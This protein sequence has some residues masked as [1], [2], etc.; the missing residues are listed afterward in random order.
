M[1]SLP[2]LM[3]EQPILYGPGDVFLGNPTFQVL[4]EETW[5]LRAADSTE[6]I[7]SCWG[8]DLMMWALL[9]VERLKVESTAETAHPTVC[10]SST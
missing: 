2:A 1:P 3:G 8:W 4:Q 7:L 10:A 6:W 9:Q 5:S